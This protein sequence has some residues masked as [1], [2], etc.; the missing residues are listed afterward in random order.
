MLCGLS[1]ATL[2]KHGAEGGKRSPVGQGCPGGRAWRGL[3]A[4][5]AVSR[6]PA[7]R[8]PG[9]SDSAVMRSDGLCREPGVRGW[10]VA[11]AAGVAQRGGGTR[12]GVRGWLCVAGERQP[13]LGSDA[14]PKITP[15]LRLWPGNNEERDLR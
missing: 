5:H 12:V 3:A 7:L 15:K 9:V 2:W 1:L 4:R 11:Q 14:E 8:V 13:W 10:R 6:P